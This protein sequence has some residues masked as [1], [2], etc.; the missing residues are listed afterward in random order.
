MTR[1]SKLALILSFVLILVVGVL[2]SDHFSQA[3]DMNQ[4]LLGQSTQQ[5]ITPLPGAERTRINNAI[6]RVLTDQEPTR[7]ATNVPL[8]QPPVQIGNGSLLSELNNT[9]NNSIDQFN[10]PALASPERRTESTN[11]PSSR[12]LGQIRHEIYTVEEGDSLYRIAAQ[13]LDDGNRW[14]E[15]QGLNRDQVGANG[16]IAVGMKLKLPANAVATTPKR[17]APSIPV[18]SNRSNAPS[19]YTVQSGDTLGEIS[20][21]L[22]GTS[23]RMNEFVKLNNLKDADSIRIG[24]KLKVPA[25]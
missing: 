7:M 11:T 4:D 20:S 21:K 17:S 13:T 1:E 18:S 5:P 14:R 19:T 2:V 23:K 6:D 9:I 15:I 12:P 3:N 10:P 8:E 16:N 22:L 25:K 24:M